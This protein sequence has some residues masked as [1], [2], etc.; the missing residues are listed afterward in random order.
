MSSHEHC[1]RRVQTFILKK[2][3]SSCLYS[4]S[5]ECIISEIVFYYKQCVLLRVIIFQWRRFV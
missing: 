1:V 5:Y 4:R 3:C 2:I